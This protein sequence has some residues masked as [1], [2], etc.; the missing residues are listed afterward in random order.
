LCLAA[1]MVDTSAASW[2]SV[3]HSLQSGHW[4]CQREVREPQ[5]WQTYR[6][7]GFAMAKP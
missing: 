1:K 3:F 7:L 4:P 5:A 6:D 2:T